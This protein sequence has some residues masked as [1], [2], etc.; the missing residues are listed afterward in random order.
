MSLATQ[1]LTLNNA[2]SLGAA[3]SWN[4]GAGRTLTV[5]GAI[6]DGGLLLGLTKTGQAH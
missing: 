4:V 3:Q 1:D 6:G 5:T 2:V